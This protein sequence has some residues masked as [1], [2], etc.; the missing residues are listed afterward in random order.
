MRIIPLNWQSYEKA[1]IVA[2]VNLVLHDLAQEGKRADALVPPL[3]EPV[4]RLERAAELAQA[5]V[6]PAVNLVP[7]SMIGALEKL[8]FEPR[9]D[10]KEVTVATSVPGI[11][12]VIR[13]ASEGLQAQLRGDNGQVHAELTQLTQPEELMEFLHAHRVEAPKLGQKVDTLVR[14]PLDDRHLVE[15]GL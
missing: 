8:G 10:E 3:M 11:T 2:G 5:E 14:R 9:E 12:L 4:H 6:K 1:A 7:K 15:L 13:P